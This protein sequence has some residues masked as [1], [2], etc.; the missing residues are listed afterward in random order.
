MFMLWHGFHYDL[1]YNMINTVCMYVCMYMYMY[2][3][4]VIYMNPF[5]SIRFYLISRPCLPSLI[6]FSSLKTLLTTIYPTNAQQVIFQITY[7][8]LSFKIIT[9][10]IFYF[11]QD[12]FLVQPCGCTL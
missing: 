3:M 2:D 8:T 5:K 9:W 1:W 12:H 6:F 10:N 7:K 4:F 11:F